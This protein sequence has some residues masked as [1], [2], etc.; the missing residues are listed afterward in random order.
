MTSPTCLAHSLTHIHIQ[1]HTR[2]HTSQI[3]TN[4]RL[5]HSKTNQLGPPWLPS[6]KPS[7]PCPARPSP[8]SSTRRTTPRNSSSRTPS[9]WTGS[10]V[11]TRWTPPRSGAK[12]PG[13]RSFSSGS[14][15]CWIHCL[16][17]T[18]L[19][20]R[21][22]GGFVVYLL[23][24]DSDWGKGMMRGGLAIFFPCTTAGDGDG[25]GIG[26]RVVVLGLEVSRSIPPEMSVYPGRFIRDADRGS[27]SGS[28][29]C[30]TNVFNTKRGRGGGRRYLSS[31]L[32]GR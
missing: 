15:A 28:C 23:R 31:A 22:P 5:V 13:K 18:S 16:G 10:S 4:Q 1:T 30:K 32:K 11:T 19:P 2:T 3:T 24:G 26:Q 7:A 27:I 8:P 29:K 6:N 25:G 20:G 12:S 14:R 21:G 17:S 9:S